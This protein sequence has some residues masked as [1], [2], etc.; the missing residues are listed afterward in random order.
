[1]IPTSRLNQQALKLASYLPV[2]S[3]PCGEVTYAIP[4]PQH[5]SQYIGRVDW[6]QSS[7]HSLFGRY[8]FADYS[9][10][11][12]FDNDLLLTTQRGVADRSQS[13]TVG[14][15]YSI[16][17]TTV[18]S[19]HA[20]WTRLAITR[21]PASD[22]INLT[23]VGVNMFSA[24]PNYMDI[25]VNG[26]FG[27]GCGSCAPAILNQDS[28]QVANDLDMVR[29]RHHISLGVDLIH[30]QFNYRNYVIANGSVTFNGGASGDALADF[31][32]GL[33]SYFEQGNLQP[34]DGRQSY[35]GAYVHD[36]IRLS[37]RLNVQLG[38]RWEPY[39]PEREKY[40]R[41]QHFDA[42][43]FAAGT[44]TN[45]YVNAPPGLFFPGDPGMP[46]ASAFPRYAIFEPRVGL[47]WD[48][49]GSGR[50]T[51]RVGY[52]LFYDTMETAYQEDQTGD[53][54]WAS[55]ID[56]PSPTGGL[57]NPFQGY[58]GGNPF[59]SPSPPIKN[60]IFPP[61]GQY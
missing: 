22:F 20:T 5:E 6:N 49:T 41:M 51:I 30:Y 15:T 16:N 23:D 43:A 1:M 61:E 54:P 40:N 24:A 25:A 50:Q 36:N 59:P 45:Q 28:Y 33:P 27:G 38:L 2:S 3:N 39:L 26:Y 58:P 11:A 46:S 35:I 52:G 14:D 57:T 60:Q 29:G 12:A 44:Q 31:M 4:E 13:V 32:L 19:L 55:T 7:K 48:P 56:L 47:A 34:F 9:S 18:N 17:A 8:F 10:P 53:S 21:G 37:K 42:A